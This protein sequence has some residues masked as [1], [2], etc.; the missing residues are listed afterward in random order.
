VSLVNQD[1]AR[2]SL[3]SLLAADRPVLVDFAYTTCTTICPLLSANFAN[4]QRTITD[5]AG[6]ACL[7]TIS[8]DPEIDSPCEM[9]SYL[10]SYQAK[11]GGDFLTGTCENI[12]SVLKAFNV[13]M[14]I[15]N[16]MDH[17]SVI[18]PGPLARVRAFVFR[19]YFIELVEATSDLLTSVTYPRLSFGTGQ[20][21]ASKGCYVVQMTEGQKPKLVKRSEW[22][23]Y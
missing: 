12:Y 22:I 16:K 5:E 6:K 7:F 14:Y 2:V 21:Y 11:A 9:K 19:D 18:L 3:R 4:F 23:I 8:V 15:W 13:Y 10:K 17:P 20:R 1:G